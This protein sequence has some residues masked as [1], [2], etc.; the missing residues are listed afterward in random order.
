MIAAIYARKSTEQTGVAE[1]QRSVTRQVEHARTYAERKDWQVAEE[2][3]YVDDGISGAEFK[4]RPGLVRL[5]N[6]LQPTPAFQVLVMSETGRVGREQV[7][8]QL[9]F[10]QLADAGV[11]I[12]SYLDDKRWSLDTATDKFL[13]SVANF[14]A[15]LEREKASQRTHDAMV[16]KARSRHVTGGRVYGYDNL[17]VLSEAAGPDGR[18]H[19]QCVIRRANPTE[20]AMVRRIF[21]LY[22]A[23]Q[24]VTRIAKTLNMEG[25][26]PPGRH[27]RGWAPTAVREI[28]RRE[29]YGGVIIWNRTR[30][31]HRGGTKGQAKR[32]ESEWVRLEAPDLRIV[33]EA[34]WQAVETRRRRAA[35]SYLRHARTGRLGGRRSGGDFESPYLLSG[36]GQCG[37]CGGSLVAMTRGHGRRRAKFYGCAY[38]HKRGATVC[39]NSVQIRQEILDGALLEAISK[40]LDEQLVEAAVERALEQLRARRGKQADRGRDLQRELLLVE[41]RMGHLLEAVKRGRA[42]AVLLETLEAEATRKKAILRELEEVDERVS[43]ASLDVRRL[44]QELKRRATDARAL[45]GR[46]VPHARRI[47]RALLEGRL[48]CEPLDEEGR[49]GYRF[50]ATGTYAG[51]FAAVGSA[52]DGRVPLGPPPRNAG[53]FGPEFRC[54]GGV[55]FPTR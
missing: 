33:P 29:L 49:R 31:V 39:S 20:A 1:D 42:T 30:K 40:A 6:A 7:L 45:L 37:V 4:N 41:A 54:R 18:R 35:E 25:I 24:G 23:G 51:L 15:E 22:A 3:I 12:W 46:H 2:H 14:A 17:E 47:L 34:L 19:R 53:V 9:A 55:S 50:R 8:T 43:I 11:E 38:H 26:A 5:L 16:R 52:N 21:A 44:A 32:P 48:A 28:L 36:L 10:S 13:L 27:T